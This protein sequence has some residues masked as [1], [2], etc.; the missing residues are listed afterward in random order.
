MKK[1]IL[2]MLAAMLALVLILTGEAVPA[3]AAGDKISVGV[4]AKFM[5]ED[6]RSMLPMINA[7]RTGSDAWYIDT[8]N[9]TRINVNGLKKLEYD[10]DLEKT[11]M[12]RAL[13][14]AVY[15]SHT[16]PSG[17]H[18]STS[19]PFPVGR[20]YMGE[21]IAYG[22]G[23]ASA[24][25]KAFREDGLAYVWQGHRRNMLHRHFTRVGFGAVRVGNFMYWAQE[26]AS[27]KAGGRASKL[28]AKA[29]N[30]SWNTLLKSN[31][32]IEP[33]EAELVILKGISVEMPKA[34]LISD[35]GARHILSGIKWK[36]SKTKFVKVKKNKLVGKTVGSTRLTARVGGK[37]LSMDVS[38]V[39]S[40]SGIN[41]PDTNIED[42]DTPLGDSEV[43]YY[44]VAP[45]DECFIAPNGA[46]DEEIPEEGTTEEEINSEED[47]S[48][49]ETP[50]EDSAEEESSSEEVPSDAES[51]AEETET[52]P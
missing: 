39:S 34:V 35:S 24:V 26:F 18:W 8:D 16:R 44:Y 28:S 25:F 51:T 48:G 31:I 15:Y 13:E 22:Y 19:Y 38:V 9:R 50:E 30:A 45:N 5:Y 46:E 4:T 23:T 17:T 41:N 2:S 12:L 10:Y 42:Y 20:Y 47:A 36:P 6:A 43:E 52:N 11:A 3:F 33:A 29:V 49:E 40:G 27:G 32:R 14:I 21:N 7:F 1:K 37:T